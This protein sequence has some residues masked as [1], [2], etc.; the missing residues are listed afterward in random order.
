M[1]YLYNV[2]PQNMHKSKNKIKKTEISLVAAGYIALSNGII[3]EFYNQC[4]S[5]HMETLVLYFM[6]VG[7]KLPKAVLFIEFMPRYIYK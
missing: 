1:T 2:L 5:S 7:K 3:S 6:F 4:K